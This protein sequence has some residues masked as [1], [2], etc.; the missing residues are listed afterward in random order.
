MIFRDI[1]YRHSRRAMFWG[2]FSLSRTS[3][4]RMHRVSGKRSFRR[5]F[6]VM[7]TN[8]STGALA[9]ILTEGFISGL[10]PF[11]TLRLF[12]HS[13][14]ISNTRTCEKLWYGTPQCPLIWALVVWRAPS[15]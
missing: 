10:W 4:V 14:T 15:R 9:R 5:K 1:N 2:E 7:E 11:Q 13:F 12:I 8:S 3:V 6:Y